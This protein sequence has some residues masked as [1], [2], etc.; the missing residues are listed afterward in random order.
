MDDH[1]LRSGAVSP[2]EADLLDR[3]YDAG[4]PLAEFADGPEQST[5]EQLELRGLARIDRDRGV[6][7]PVLP[8]APLARLLEEV[9][10]VLARSQAEVLRIRERVPER[11]GGVEVAAGVEL[12]PPESGPREHA[13]A[14]ASRAKRS[15]DFVNRRVLQ[16]PRKRERD[17]EGELLER[18]VRV[19][20]LYARSALEP[21][22]SLADLLWGTTRGE[23]SR[24]TSH[25]SARFILIDR[26]TALLPAQP[27]NLYTDGLLVVRQRSL[28]EALAAFFDLLWHEAVPLD[29]ASAE[30]EP[31]ARLD[32]IDRGRGFSDADR[33]LAALLAS[34]MSDRAIGRQLEVSERTAHRR[35]TDLLT[36]LGA[37]TRFQ[38]GA[39]AVRHGLLAE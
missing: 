20:G 28:V 12:V 3:L 37:E 6:V 18:G 1:S 27:E 39:Q 21:P 2:A 30:D 7:R 10:E 5:I 14:L 35:V 38:A 19:R 17:I 22:G 8:F 36:R 11:A 16:P 26:E 13:F 33:A 4:L 32:A 31:R 23:E 25:P 34:G 24:A 9:T 29:A 15:F